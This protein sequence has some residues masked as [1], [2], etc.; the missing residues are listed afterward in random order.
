MISSDLYVFIEDGVGR[1][2]PDF[3]VLSST[4]ENKIITMNSSVKLLLYS[5]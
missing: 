3:F 1:Q 2:R 4:S 5:N